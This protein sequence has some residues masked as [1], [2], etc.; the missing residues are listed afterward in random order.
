ML[1]DNRSK[2]IWEDTKIELRLKD[3]HKVYWIQIIDA[4]PKM[5]KDDIL[6]DN[7]NSKNL[8]VFNHHIV[9]KSLIKLTSKELYLILVDKNTVK[10]TTQDY[11]ENLSESSKFN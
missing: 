7:G 10:L 1:N 6:K 4:L 3:T 11:F 9:R 5:W 8:V 2:K